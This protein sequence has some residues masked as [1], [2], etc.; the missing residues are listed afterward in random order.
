M[1]QMPTV[2]CLS[3]QSIKEVGCCDVGLS[4]C[5]SLVD[6]ARR[7]S[8]ALGAQA[9]DI[10]QSWKTIACSRIS[11]SIDSTSAQTQGLRQSP[12]T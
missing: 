7:G 11:I 5:S 9:M 10:A 4:G 8:G 1:D 12:S 6:E 2:P 3:D